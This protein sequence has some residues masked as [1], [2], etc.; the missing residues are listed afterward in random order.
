MSSLRTYPTSIDEVATL[1]Y[2]NQIRDDTKL[3]E[4]DV[5]NH[6][7]RLWAGL[8]AKSQA[9]TIEQETISDVLMKLDAWLRNKLSGESL[10]TLLRTAEGRYPHFIQYMPESLAAR[11]EEIRIARIWSS[12]LDP[13][14]LIKLRAGIEMER[15]VGGSF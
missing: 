14:A 11:Y 9:G 5:I 1:L 6:V 4:V 15:E 10:H 7:E 3:I 13:N 8:Q 12:L 2:S